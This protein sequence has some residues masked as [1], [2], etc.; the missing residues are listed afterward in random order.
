MYGGC[1]ACG[2]VVKSSVFMR[3]CRLEVELVIIAEY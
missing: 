3:V 2:G 1:Y